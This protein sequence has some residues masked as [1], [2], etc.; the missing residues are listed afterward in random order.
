MSRARRSPIAAAGSLGSGDEGPARDLGDVGY[1]QGKDS[2]ET[3]TAIMPSVL[4]GRV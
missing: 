3:D 2:D 4:P 1:G